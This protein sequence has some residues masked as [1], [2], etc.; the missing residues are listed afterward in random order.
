[1][2]TRYLPSEGTR[3]AA[4]ASTARAIAFETLEIQAC[5]ISE[6]AFRVGGC[7]FMRLLYDAAGMG[8]VTTGHVL[9]LLSNRG[10]LRDYTK[11]KYEA[12]FQHWGES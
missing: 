3:S 9:H 6:S 4:I 12:T 1:V 7:G 5:H 10:R 2:C 11:R 8:W